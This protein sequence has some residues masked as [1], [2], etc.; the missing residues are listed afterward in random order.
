MDQKAANIIS[1]GLN[2]FL[3]PRID[4]RVKNQ[5]SYLAQTK[6]LIDNGKRANIFQNVARFKGVVLRV[7]NASIGGPVARLFGFEF[8]SQRGNTVGL[9]VRVPEL[10]ASLP[11]PD[12]ISSGLPS[13]RDDKI[14]DLYPLFYPYNSVLASENNAQF[15]PGS[16]IYVDFEDRNN[17]TGGIYYDLVDPSTAMA[18]SAGGSSMSGRSAFSGGGGASS[19]AAG[20]YRSPFTTDEVG[21]ITRSQVSRA[22]ASGAIDPRRNSPKL[23]ILHTSEGNDDESRSDDRLIESWFRLATEGR[24]SDA[25]QTFQKICTHFI[26]RR[27]G[28]IINFIPPIDL[29]TWH[30]GGAD[31]GSGQ[32]WNDIA[33]GIDLNTKVGNN[34]YGNEGGVNMSRPMIEALNRLIGCREMV[35]LPI[36]GHGSHMTIGTAGRT[37]PG[38]DFDWVGNIGADRTIILTE[39]DGFHDHNRQVS[40]RAI[41]EK[42]AS[43]QGRTSDYSYHDLLALP[44]RDVTAMFIG[45]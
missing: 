28:R 25:R 1:I 21:G 42:Y 43:L 15:I 40:M 23:I 13:T 19:P 17:M 3:T 2:N 12:F 22:P 27:N 32:R 26:I 20:S 10:H 37:D 30:C 5:E 18:M 24:W 6:R 39:G 35:N 14:I 44:N 31:P 36:I 38:L 7:E 41:D 11:I 16:L 34:D 29:K 4:K 45:G 8:A 9:R 33:I